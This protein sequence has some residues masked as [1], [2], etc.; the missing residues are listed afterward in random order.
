MPTN[1]RPPS[2]D[3]RPPSPDHRP[4]EGQ[5]GRRSAPQELVA[6]DFSDTE[7]VTVIE[8]MSLSFTTPSG[9][10]SDT[11]DLT[12]QPAPKDSL[13]AGLLQVKN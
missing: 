3:Y 9:C 7:E 5:A 1:Y 6:L 11:V 4:P 13:H 10:S 2:T 8:P 12:D